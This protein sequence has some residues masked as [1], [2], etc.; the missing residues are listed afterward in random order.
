MKSRKAERFA[1]FGTTIFAEMSALAL[2][3]GAINLS[4][5]FPDFDGPAF[6]KDAVTRAMGQ[7]RNQYAAMPGTPELR[8]A[9]AGWFGGSSGLEVDPEREVTVTAGCTEAIAAALLGLVNPGERVVVFEPFYDSYRACLAM[10]GAHGAWVTLRPGADGRFGFEEAEL[11]E[12][13]A[14]AKAILVNTPHNPTGKVFTRAELELI[15]DLCVEHDA[16]AIVDEVYERLWYEDD[17]PHVHLA[18]IDGMGDRTLTL[19]SL[20]KS[21]S[22]TGWKIGWA[23]GPPHLTAGVRAAHQFLTFAVATPLQLGAAAALT[24]GEESVRELCAHYRAMRDLLGEALTRCGLGVVVPEGS[25]FIMADHT[26][27]SGAR[28]FADDVAFCKWL[29]AEVGVAAIP[30]SAFYATP[31]HGARFA[32]FAFCKTEETM[33]KA[34]ERLEKG[35]G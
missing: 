29:T 6:V 5:G 12:A 21:F 23:I 35:L 24:D 10:A 26:R 14:G 16:I 4:Q 1:P 15:R 7:G 34:I 8:R 17:R 11:R 33:R 9:V 28:G 30:P 25:Y 18:A 22:L 27:V 32:R 3:H 13:F 31:S 19:S 2:E 20:G